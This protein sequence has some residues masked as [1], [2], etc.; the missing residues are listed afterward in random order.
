[1]ILAVRSKRGTYLACDSHCSNPASDEAQK[2]FQCGSS[3]FIAISGTVVA[4]GSAVYP[5]G[6][7]VS[8]TL[9][10]MELLDRVCSDYAGDNTDLVE[11]VATGVFHPLWKFWQQCVVPAPEAFLA[12]T[13]PTHDSVLTLSGIATIG[14][15]MRV[16]EIQFPFLRT[17]QL[18]QLVPPTVK[19]FDH[20]ITGWGHTVDSDGID[21]DLR[22]GR[23]VVPFILRMYARSALK[24][25]DAVGGPTDIG[26]LDKNGARWISRKSRN[27]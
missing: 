9:D 11:Y 20:E 18:G 23:G 19:D 1:M 26:F 4:R 13:P 27:K 5:D 15:S 8:G 6:K 12:K 17:G 14:S 10:L 25:P 16:F 24:Y 2:I 7:V 3:A 22:R 21:F